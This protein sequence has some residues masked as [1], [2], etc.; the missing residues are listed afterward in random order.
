[1]FALDEQSSKRLSRWIALVA[2][3]TVLILVGVGGF[4]LVQTGRARAAQK[5]IVRLKTEIAEAGRS[6]KATML[7]ADHGDRIEG[8][9]GKST[10]NRFMAEVDKA[11]RRNAC[12][13]DFTKVA[14]PATF[15]SKFRNEVD[16]T[17]QQIEVGMI[18]DGELADVF[19]TLS[20]F[21]EF[22]IPF[23]FGTM[24]IQR[25][26]AEKQGLVHVNLT[27]M[28]LIPIGGAKK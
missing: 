28:V 11:S 9:I 3:A 7:V 18:I 4:A 16:G 1:M 19:R 23:E 8:P 15:I 26:A 13:A 10:A 17:L 14:D 24:D 22:K 12:R 5:N 25:G 20:E 21:S 6:L 2:T 27:V